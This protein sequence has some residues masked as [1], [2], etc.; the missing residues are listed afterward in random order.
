[1]DYDHSEVQL[2]PFNGDYYTE[3]RMN[4]QVEVIQA[5][6]Q[7]SK[8]AYEQQLSDINVIEKVT[9]YKKIDWQ[10][11]EILDHF[12]LDMPENELRTVGLCLKLSEDTVETLRSEAQW[13]SD[14]NQ[15]G[16]EWPKIRKMVL[17]RDQYRCQICGSHGNAALLHVHHRIPFRSFHNTEEANQLE[18][19][20]TLCPNC[21]KIAE[22]NVKIRSGLGGFAYL[23]TQIAPLYLMCDQYDIGSFV[24]PASK[25]NAGLPMV[26]VYDQFPGG[27]GLSAELYNSAEEV[28]RD[29]REV[30]ENC[31]CKDGCPACVGPAGENGIGGKEAALQIVRKLLE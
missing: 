16:R 24:D 19:L 26:V 17:E 13:N 31:E 1:M 30:I 29:C 20:I 11:H 5:L 9:G 18:N 27:I 28:M 3:P 10:T 21:H 8:P 4:S 25:Y 12:D 22:Q 15:Y 14:P 6:R 2:E 23:F 7:S